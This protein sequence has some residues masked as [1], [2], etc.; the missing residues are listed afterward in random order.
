VTET[1]QSTEAGSRSTVTEHSGGPTRATT[2]A[3]DTTGADATAGATGAD[4][5]AGATGA[6]TTAGATGA[7]TTAGATG[8]DTTTGTTGADTTTGTTGA[9]T[10]TGTTGVGIAP[11]RAQELRERWS[12]VKGEFVDDPKS[13]ANSARDVAGEVLEELERALRKKHGTLGDALG[14]DPKTEELRVAINRYQEFS[15]RLLSF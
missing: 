1:N 4:T 10:T 2:S 15:E 14:S 12:A 9:D 5:T 6:D 7:D 3:V 11:E 8:A 13:A